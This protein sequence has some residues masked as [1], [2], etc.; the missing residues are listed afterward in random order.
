MTKPVT[1]KLLEIFTNIYQELVDL[2]SNY[3]ASH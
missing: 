2:M 3:A 1:K